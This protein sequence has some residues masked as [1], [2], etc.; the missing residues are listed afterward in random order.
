MHQSDRGVQH[1]AIRRTERLAE[2]GMDL[3]VGSTGDSNTNAA[4]R[5]GIALFKAEEII[6]AGPGRAWRTSSSRPSRGSCGTKG[7]RLLEPLG[8]V[9]PAEFEQVYHDRQTALADMAVLTERALR[10]TRGRFTNSVLLEQ[11]LCLLARRRGAIAIGAIGW[12]WT[13]RISPPS[14]SHRCGSIREELCPRT[15]TGW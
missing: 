7:R 4:G 9:P 14:R 3:S 10:R 11:L 1:L 15:P 8:Y 6:D 13:A 12:R 5:D 2:A